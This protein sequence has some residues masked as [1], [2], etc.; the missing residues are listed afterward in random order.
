MKIGGVVFVRNFAIMTIGRKGQRMSYTQ[1]RGS[2]VRAYERRNRETWA[3]MIDLVNAAERE[4]RALN[5]A[6][7]FIEENGRIS[8]SCKSYGDLTYKFQ[9]DEITAK[10]RRP[11]DASLPGLHLWC[12]QEGMSIFECLWIDGIEEQH[13]AVIANESNE[14]PD[15]QMKFISRKAELFISKLQALE[16]VGEIRRLIDLEVR[17]HHYREKRCRKILEIKAWDLCRRRALIAYRHEWR[18]ALETAFAN[19]SVR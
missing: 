13:L 5:K 17:D 12:K 8:N 9:Y 15:W 14:K 6:N 11:Y 18:A 4:H 7:G 1:I 2:F 3:K 19:L 10:Y 16:R